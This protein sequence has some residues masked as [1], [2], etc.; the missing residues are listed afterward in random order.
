MPKRLAFAGLA[1]GALILIGLLNAFFAEE[2]PEVAQ[3]ARSSGGR[4]PIAAPS[5]ERGEEPAARAAASPSPSASATASPSPSEPEGKAASAAKPSSRSRSRKGRRDTRPRVTVAGLVVDPRGVPVAGAR[6]VAR[7]NRGGGWAEA[8]TD[9]LGRFELE[10]RARQA[11]LSARPPKGAPGLAT[12]KGVRWSGPGEELRYE[13]GAPLRLGVGVAIVGRV[14]SL[15]GE[16]IAAAKVRAWGRSSRSEATSDA[17][18]N[19]RIEGLAEAVYDVEVR[20]KGFVKESLRVPVTLERGGEASFSLSPAGSLAGVVR[21]ADGQPVSRASVF[22]FREGEELRQ[23][24]TDRQGSYSL[25]SLAPGPVEV[26]VR[27]RDRT[28]TARVA[29][30]VQAG[31]QASLDLTM[32]EGAKV[33]GVLSDVEGNRLAK[34]Q[35]RVRNASGQVRRRGESDEAGN[36]EVKGLYPGTYTITARPPNSRGSLVE[37]EIEV[38]SG[39]ITHDLV[40]SLGARISGRVLDAEGKPVRAEVHALQGED[41]LGFARC[42][43]DGGFVLEDLKPGSYLLFLRRRSRG[44]GEL[45][46]RHKLEVR[47]GEQREDL[48]LS[49]YRPAKIRGRLSGVDVARL[50]GLRVR[51]NSVRGSVNRR[52]RTNAEGTFEMQPFYDGEYELSVSSSRL[53]L[54][55]RDL[56]VAKLVVDPVRVRIEGGR[57][58]EVVLQ[59]RVAAE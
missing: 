1:F 22:A 49:V 28:Q 52:A 9:A 42:G 55:A 38:T 19:F 21:G 51:A 25:E 47:A 7:A 35:V 33:R 46:G 11:Y 5:R 37:E 15:E 24:T 29:A 31:V 59:V 43:E 56:G 45:V 44:A 13:L 20:A 12:A 39:V 8:K 48:E 3:S 14:R 10:L 2:E 34:W 53:D 57:D 18:G 41:T 40:A 26:F 32:N 6:V 17:E 58:Q 16:P 54:L 30:Q 23:A 50:E 27:S 4:T 36:F